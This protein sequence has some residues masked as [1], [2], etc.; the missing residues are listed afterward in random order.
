MHPYRK[1]LAAHTLNSIVNWAAE[2]TSMRLVT[3]EH[4]NGMEKII[5]DHISRLGDMGFCDTLVVKEEG[6]EFG[7]FK[8]KNCP[9]LERS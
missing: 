3:L 5:T 6:K 1:F 4:I 8:F 2:I 9:P 7:H